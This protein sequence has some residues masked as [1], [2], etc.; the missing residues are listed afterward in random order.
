VHGLMM[1]RVEVNGFGQKCAKFWSTCL[2]RMEKEKTIYRIIIRSIII[3]GSE[4][5]TLSRSNENTLKCGK[6]KF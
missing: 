3:Y 2:L 1:K 4:I 5:W 6:G